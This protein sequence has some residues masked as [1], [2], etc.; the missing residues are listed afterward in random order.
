M[1]ATEKQIK[2]F[3]QELGALCVAESNRRIAAGQ[4]FI[5]PS[6]ALVQSALETGYGTAGIMTRANAYFGIKAGGSWTGK[7]YRADTWEVAP[8]GTQYNIKANFR[9]YDDSAESVRDY[10]DLMTQASRYAKAVCYGS[11]PSK[12]LTA[13]Q[14]VEALHAAGYATDQLYVSKLMNMIEYRNFTA[15]DAKITGVAGATIPSDVPNKIFAASKHVQGTL[16]ASDGGRSV[17]ND[18]TATNAVALLWDNA[19]TIAGYSVYKLSGLGSYQLYLATVKDDAAELLG[20]YEDGAT[21][22]IA[23][24]TT[25]GYYIKKENGDALSL[26]DLGDLEV[27]FD[28]Q[29]DIDGYTSGSAR[30]TDPIAFFV[31]IE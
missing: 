2:K 23:A 14:T 6:V 7:I 28:A 16:I 4:G 5:L 31:K 15:Y 18:R 11:D 8:N 24:G 9:A 25:V 17:Q 3:M 30:Y 29:N 10:Y 13:R 1:A 21:L 27:F 20:P 26:A 19:F 22:E 12:W